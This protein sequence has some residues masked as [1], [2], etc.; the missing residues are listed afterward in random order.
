MQIHEKMGIPLYLWIHGIKL[1][2]KPK[3]S[4]IPNFRTA[5]MTYVGLQTYSADEF[6]IRTTQLEEFVKQAFQVSFSAKFLLKIITLVLVHVTHLSQTDPNL[7]LHEIVHFHKSL[8]ITTPLHH[9][10]SS[11][12]INSSPPMV[13]Q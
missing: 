2:T 11:W 7:T 10:E 3:Y 1:N 4:Q 13:K 8:Q 9:I 6:A 12:Q 5:I